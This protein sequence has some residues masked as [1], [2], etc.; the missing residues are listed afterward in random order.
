MCTQGL[1]FVCF[2]STLSRKECCYYPVTLVFILILPL[3]LEIQNITFYVPEVGRKKKKHFE[4]S[5]AITSI[6]TA[7]KVNVQEHFLIDANWLTVRS[8]FCTFSPQPSSWRLKKTGNQ[9]NQFLCTLVFCNISSV[10]VSTGRV[11]HSISRVFQMHRKLKLP[12]VLCT[13]SVQRKHVSSHLMP[14]INKENAI[15]NI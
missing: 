4:M 2:C 14:C 7:W 11:F 15:L 1:Y 8:F 5:F 9:F 13:V 6:F 12:I 3:L 10:S